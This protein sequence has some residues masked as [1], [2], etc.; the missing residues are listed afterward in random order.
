MR[1]RAID[2]DHIKSSTNMASDRN[3]TINSDPRKIVTL[4]TLQAEEQVGRRHLKH[5]DGSAQY[6][7]ATSAAKSKHKHTVQFADDVKIHETSPKKSTTVVVHESSSLRGM[8]HYQVLPD[9]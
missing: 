9:G 6:P 5:A 2:S 1:K 3:P 4:A 8:R 7:K